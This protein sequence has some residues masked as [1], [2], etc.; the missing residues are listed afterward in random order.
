MF[1]WLIAGVVLAVAV[2]LLI[3]GLAG[4]DP[5]LLAKLLRWV[6]IALVAAVGV[7]LLATGRFTQALADVAVLGL[8]L[9]RYSALWSRIK[10]AMGPKPGQR[11]AVE[12]PWITMELDH[13]SGQLDGD[14]RQGRFAGRRLSALSRDELVELLEACRSADPQGVPLVETF[15]DRMHPDWRGAEQREEAATRTGAGGF[16]EAMTPAEA[17]RILGVGEDAGESA[18]K[19]AHRRLMLKNHPDQGGSTYIAAKIN[20]AKDVLLKKRR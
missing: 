5:R 8:L 15:L 12:T 18:I 11:S 1:F 9:T 7:F 14:V 3:R 2:M 20:Q 13:D 19:E 6:A 4:A 17:R 16:A 10:S